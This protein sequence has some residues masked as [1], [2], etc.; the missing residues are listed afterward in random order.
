MLRLD[1]SAV[2]LW[3]EAKEEFSMSKSGSIELEHSLYAISRWEEKYEKPFLSA[4]EG[5]ISQEE[6]NDYLAMAV[7][8]GD[9]DLLKYL[10]DQDY[11]KIEDYFSGK[12]T[13]STITNRD[14]KK[15]GRSN[16][17]GQ[18]VTSELL[19]SYMVAL[20]IPFE[21]QYWNI[22][23]LMML[24]NICN[25]QNKPS[26]SM[27]KEKNMSNMA[28]LNKARRAKLGSAG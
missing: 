2:E 17:R 14:D 12:H 8:K 9:P 15:H 13:A 22:N 19:Y 26:K 4:P 23:R 18:F 21:A 28:K 25:E 7:V 16:G 10:S 20:R 1:I 24:I 11:K 5:S 3:N 27:P 6:F